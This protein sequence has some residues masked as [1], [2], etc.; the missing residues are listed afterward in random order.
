[1]IPKITIISMTLILLSNCNS[2]KPA[3]NIVIEKENLKCKEIYK[4]YNEKFVLEE[5]DSALIYINQA[6][7]C[8]PK[9][10]NYKYT[11]IR[12]LVDINN[13][14][15]AIK[16]LDKF[17]PN[18]D[19]PAFKMQKGILMLKINDDNSKQILEESYFEYNKLIEPTSNNLFYKIAL[20]NYFKSKEY[21][22]NEIL[23]FK[24]KY[25][26]KDYE[27]QNIDALESLVKSEN[28]ENVLFKLF[29]I[30]D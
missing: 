21:A 26:G 7:E 8:N 22:L 16:E 10:T 24:N 25:K 3:S 14:N 11:K 27:M 19:D 18:S 12:F 5:N 13:Y 29:N 30:S 15:D 9:S 2:K 20:D 17:I 4:K 1:M 6:I 28:K 23:N